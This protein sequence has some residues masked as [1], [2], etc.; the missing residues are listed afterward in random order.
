MK[1][2]EV[3]IKAR[4]SETDG[5]GVIYH[6]NYYSWFEMG[7]YK[8]IDDFFEL[9]S[10][11]L[12]FGEVYL[13][14]VTSHCKYIKFCRFNDEIIIRTFFV[15]DDCARLCFHSEIVNKKSNII[16]ASGYTKHVIVDKNYNIIYKR[17]QCIND[18]IEKMKEDFPQ[19]TRQRK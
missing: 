8:F 13:P 15:C 3:E 5:M 19:Y 10:K 11:Q 1:T 17:P 12:K 6:A 4:F 2:N 16:C 7:R 14:V 9:S 18:D